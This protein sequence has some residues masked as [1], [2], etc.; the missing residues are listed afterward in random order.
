MPPEQ[1]FSWRSSSSSTRSWPGPRTARSPTGS[2]NEFNLSP[3][4]ND[5]KS[6][7]SRKLPEKLSELIHKAKYRTKNRFRNILFCSNFEKFSVIVIL[8]GFNYVEFKVTLLNFIQSALYCNKIFKE[9]NFQK[10]LK[11]EKIF[12][13]NRV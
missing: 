4:I 13:L 2:G 10:V 3:R 8:L 6:R 9:L 12:F 1:S 7:P 11:I 5:K